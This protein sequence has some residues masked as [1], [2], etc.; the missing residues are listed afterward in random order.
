MRGQARF[1]RLYFTIC[2]IT[3][4]FTA[5]KCFAGL[6]YLHLIMLHS[7]LIKNLY[8]LHLIDTCVKN[9]LQMWIPILVRTTTLLSLE[10]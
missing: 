7:V 2:R 1:I 5:D 3:L 6:K 10:S 4:A 8:M 9:N